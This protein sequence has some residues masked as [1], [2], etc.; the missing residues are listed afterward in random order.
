MRLTMLFKSVL[1]NEEEEGCYLTLENS[2]GL[3]F[4]F[5]GI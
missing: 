2:H 5:F 3:Q 1:Q 4:Q